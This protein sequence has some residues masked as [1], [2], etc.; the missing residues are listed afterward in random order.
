MFEEELEM[1]TIF[2]KV[3]VGVSSAALIAGLTLGMN[4]ASNVKAA[5]ADMLEG[6]SWSC[7]VNSYE[8]WDAA[9]LDSTYTGLSNAST[10]QESINGVVT[11]TTTGKGSGF[12]ANIAFTGWQYMQWVQPAENLPEGVRGIPQDGNFNYGDMPFQLNST[13]NAKVVPEKTYKLHMKIQNNMKNDQGIPTEKNVTISVSS[14]IEGDKDNTFLFKTVR[15]PANG[16][17]EVNENVEI[18][19]F[20]TAETVQIQLGYGA[21]S[22]SYNA[23]ALGY[24]EEPDFMYAYGTTE[25]I[26]ATGSL[27]FSDVSFVGEKA[28]APTTAPVVTTKTNPTTKAPVTTKTVTVKKL[29]KV[30][31]LTL[32]NPKKATVKIAWKK[33]ANAKKYQIKVGTKSYDST[34][35]KKTVTNKKFKKGKKVTVK[36]RATATGYK[37]GAWA[38]KSIKIKK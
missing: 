29:G 16:E 33:V 18:N 30:S 15:V 5:E 36:V 26:N 7:K 2:K 23:T 22:Y 31:K 13:I 12:T 35:T 14:G 10:S 27:T 24:D 17:L 8:Q 25:N 3:A 9:I 37:A 11:K 21:Y 6:Q 34:K 38:K 1:N 32:K 4:T 19:E 28:E 20:Y